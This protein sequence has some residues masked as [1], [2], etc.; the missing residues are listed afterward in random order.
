[1][2]VRRDECVLGGL[3]GTENEDKLNLSAGMLVSLLWFSVFQRESFNKMSP[4]E[5]RS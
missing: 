1:M 3:A 2:L 5:N 4:E